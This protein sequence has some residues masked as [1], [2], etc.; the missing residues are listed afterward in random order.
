MTELSS[1][2]VLLVCSSVAS[3]LGAVIGIYAGCTGKRYP[4]VIFCVL[5]LV[6]CAC[7]LTAYS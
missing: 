3:V 4:V 7:V 5:W 2:F 1:T 6:L